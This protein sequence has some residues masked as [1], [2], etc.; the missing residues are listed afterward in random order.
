M[1]LFVLDFFHCYV[2]LTGQSNLS[3]KFRIRL[4][5]I[6]ILIYFTEMRPKHAVKLKNS[7]G[8]DKTAPSV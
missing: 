6:S 8:H 1:Y 4:I 5:A 7:V 3:I 2:I